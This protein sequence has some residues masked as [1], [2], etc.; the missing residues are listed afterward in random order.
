[1]VVFQRRKGNKG[2][3]LVIRVRDKDKRLY[4]PIPFFLIYLALLLGKAGIKIA[5][6]F[7]SSEELRRINDITKYI[8]YRSIRKLVYCLWICKS[9][10]LVKVCDGDSMVI[11]DVI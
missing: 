3:I 5:N 2:N 8:D 1:L 4:I 7:G 9:T 10:G 11:I 6:R